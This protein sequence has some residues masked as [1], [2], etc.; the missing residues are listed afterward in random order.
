MSDIAKRLR[1]M[2]DQ[3]RKEQENPKTTP[4]THSFP[5]RP[6]RIHKWSERHQRPKQEF[7][8]EM[9]QE[10]RATKD[11]FDANLVLSQIRNQVNRLQDLLS[12]NPSFEDRVENGLGLLLEELSSLDRMLNADINEYPKEQH[13]TLI[14]TRDAFFEQFRQEMDDFF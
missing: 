3:I 6:E 13:D 12:K 10:E 11:L 9:T 5:Q 1:E 7:T 4:E 2:A 14:R 8:L